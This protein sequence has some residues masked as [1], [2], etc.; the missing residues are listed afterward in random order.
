LITARNISIIILLSIAITLSSWS[1]ILSN[2]D[3]HF[4]A[5]SNP[6]APDV[7]MKDVVATILNKQGIPSLQLI[8]PS[9]IH[10]PDHDTTQI[11]S[12]KVTVFRHELSP[13]YIDADFAK[14]TQG[15][16]QILFWSHVNI[17]HPTDADN[18]KTTLKTE[19]LT[20]FPNQKMA[21]T[22]QPVTF[23]QPDTTVYAVGMLANMDLGTIQLLSQ[24]RGEYAPSS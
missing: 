2:T 20:I 4:H 3:N 13:W 14:S 6:Q 7:F 9:M 18:P 22:D 21:S 12:P 19:S 8:T 24:A 15:I 5:P 11:E 1:I 17:H 23:I 16:N 10:Y